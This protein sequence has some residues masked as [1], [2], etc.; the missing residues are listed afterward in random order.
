V[1]ADLRLVLS[2]GLEID[3]LLLTGESLAVRRGKLII[4]E[5]ILANRIPVATNPKAKPDL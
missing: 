2:H 1:P 5:V 3:E 4:T